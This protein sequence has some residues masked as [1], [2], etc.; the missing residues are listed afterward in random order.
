MTEPGPAGTDAELAEYYDQH[1]DLTDWSEPLS[2]P[3]PERLE[4][5]ISVR[6]TP[7]EIATIRAR[8][9]AAGLKPTTFIRRCALA[10]EQPP[11]DRGRLS[12]SVAAL[13]RDLEDLR[14]AA[15]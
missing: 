3:K 7:A 4:V 1:R 11:I 8:A 6:F 10:D 5:T 12:R 15:G 2:M 13:S 9:E 14:C